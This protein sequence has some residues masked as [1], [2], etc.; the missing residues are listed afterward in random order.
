VDPPDVRLER[1]VLAGT[2]LHLVARIATALCSLAASA[3]N[4]RWLGEAGLGRFSFHMNLFVVAGTL[5]DLGSFAIAVR[6][7]S[8]R[9]Q[10]EEAILRASCRIRMRAILLSI[11]AL[12][13]VAFSVEATAR[14]A[15]LP[16]LAA[17][18]LLAIAPATAGAWL[19]TRVRLAWLA[20][21][22]VLGMGA[23]LAGSVALRAAG[24]RDPGWFL[25]AWGAGIVVQSLVP[26]A[27]TRA[28][29]RLGWG[30]VNPFATTDR[31]LER[32]LFREMAPLGVSSAVATLAFR[33]D[34]NFLRRLQD[35]AAVGRFQHA[36]Q[37]LSFSINVPSNLT[38][39]LVPSLV[40]ASERA[41][42]EVVR[43]TRRVGAVLA[44][45]CLPVAAIA[46]GWSAQ[47]LWLLWVRQGTGG[48]AGFELWRATHGDEITSA[49]L[50]AG[51]AVAIFLTYPQMNALLAL[52][53]QRLLCAISVGALLAKSALS[54]FTVAEFGVV[55]AAAT[56]LTIECAVCVTAGVALARAV[57]GAVFSRQLVR[58][59]LP[60]LAAGAVAWGLRDLAPVSAAALGAVLVALSV[61]L[62]RTFPLRLPVA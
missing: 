7:S 19:Q 47:V 10:D 32:E 25:V 33:L 27:A 62:A 12:A 54:L 3:L 57:G 29:L 9:P 37:L 11:A 38:A 30:A 46:Q 28:H 18:H 45:L 50:L 24:V 5:V 53:R 43:L 49:R 26:W 42:S 34:S 35:D 48:A 36:F 58:P 8:R 23:W 6:E 20:L 55:G 13:V 51:A 16:S 40:R 52:S 41:P 15:L 61:V 44:G 4:F 31:A 60:A 2:G 56:T 1:R 14:D 22:P 21:S 17:C 39:A 59:L